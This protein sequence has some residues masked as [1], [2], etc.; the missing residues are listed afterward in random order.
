MSTTF[1][2]SLIGLFVGSFLNVVIKRLPIII[3]Y[4]VKE[5]SLS[6]KKFN[7]I[8]PRSFCFF[9]GKKL[10]IIENIPILSYLLQSGRC[11]SCKK[12]ISPSYLCV[13]L[14]SL[15]L[16]AILIW[17]YGAGFFG[18]SSLIFVWFTIVLSV[19]DF[20]N[21]ILPDELTLLLMWIGIIL[22]YFNIFVT[23]ED[24]VLGAIVG[25]LF[26]W[27]IF[28]VYFLISKKEGIGYGD[29]KF[30][31][32]LGAWFGWKSLPMILITSSVLGLI[33]GITMIY[34]YSHRSNKPIPFGPFLGMGGL[35]CII[36]S[37]KIN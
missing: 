14:I 11:K 29:L 9:C 28:W 30:L 34:L 24:S 31:A 6:K 8:S 15:I 5:K 27:I 17:N 10:S 1:F 22:S 19:I 26:F 25:Y 20:Q 23:L 16:S 13:E 21:K 2:W 35:L 3:G 32:A 36:L 37:N 12:K 18:V 33:Y 7:L 4:E